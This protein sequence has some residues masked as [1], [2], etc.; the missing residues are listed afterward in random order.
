MKFRLQSLKRRRVGA[1]LLAAALLI[2]LSSP[3][4]PAE[5]AKKAKGPNTKDFYAIQSEVTLSGAGTGYH[6]KLAYVTNGSAI[7]YGIQ[8][9]EFASAPYTG[10]DAL[11]VENVFN[12]NAGGQSYDWLATLNPGQT[13]TLM[14]TLTKS[15]R[16][17]VYLDGKALKSYQ[18]DGLKTNNSTD[19]NQYMANPLPRVE[20]AGRMNGD[21]VDARFNNISIKEGSYVN[22]V[23]YEP[24]NSGALVADPDKKYEFFLPNAIKANPT[25]NANIKSKKSVQI[26]GSIS[27]LPEG[28][29]WDSAY[30]DVSGIVQWI[31]NAS[32]FLPKGH[33]DHT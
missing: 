22:G 18:N 4:M 30:E 13:Y 29:D 17:T 25:M 27:G 33:P 6:A 14:L 32:Y 11:M 23:K 5:A 24:T 15:G 16:A 26:G 9:D 31:R 20:G 7:S 1:G 8:H 28:K 19:L 2:G 12:N 10:V 21:V 3:A